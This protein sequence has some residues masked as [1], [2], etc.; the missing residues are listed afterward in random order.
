VGR[1]WYAPFVVKN[2]SLLSK[3]HSAEICE[4]TAAIPASA[5]SSGFLFARLPLP[6]QLG[7]QAVWD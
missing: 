1:I 6:L 7:Q 4:G 2:K 3:T 5:S